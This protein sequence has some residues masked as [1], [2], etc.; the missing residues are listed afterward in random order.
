MGSC[1]VEDMCSL[2]TEKCPFKVLTLNGIPCSCPIKEGSYVINDGVFP[3]PN[4]PLSSLMS[5]S[6]KVKV[7]VQNGAKEN[8]GCVE[9]TLDL[10]IT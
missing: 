5:G 10:Q 7:Q 1:V 2:G 3:L 8:L 6:Y 9:A 4:I